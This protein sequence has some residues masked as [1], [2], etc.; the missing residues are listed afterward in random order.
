ML[1]VHPVVRATLE[2]NNLLVVVNIRDYLLSEMHQ[3]VHDRFVF[4]ILDQPQTHTA[5]EEYL[6]DF[7]QNYVFD[8]LLGIGSFN[9]LDKFGE[10]L[11]SIPKV[12]QKKLFDILIQT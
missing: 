9:K 6:R 2:L 12:L 3:L 7:L 11:A 5:M 8:T 10:F 1:E 4:D